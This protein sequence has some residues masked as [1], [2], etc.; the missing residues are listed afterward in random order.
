MKKNYNHIL[1]VGFYKEIA[2]FRRYRPHKKIAL[3]KMSLTVNSYQCLKARKDTEENPEIDNSFHTKVSSLVKVFEPKV[4]N[5]HATLL[6]TRLPI[7]NS[8]II[9]NSKRE[10]MSLLDFLIYDFKIIDRLNNKKPFFSFNISEDYKR[11]TVSM[12]IVELEE[13]ATYSLTSQFNFEIKIVNINVDFHFK[14]Q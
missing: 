12:P 9:F 13:I 3:Q 7:Y 6:N 8:K 5:I 10:I 1:Y 14:F 2:R 11:L 4:S